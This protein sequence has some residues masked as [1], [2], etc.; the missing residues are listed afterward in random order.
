[1]RENCKIL[2]PY[3]LWRRKKDQL[4]E[5]AYILKLK[6]EI[7]RKKKEAEEK[8]ALERERKMTRIEVSREINYFSLSF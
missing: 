5:A 7:E 2:R 3:I 4:V 6:R 1:M 8:K